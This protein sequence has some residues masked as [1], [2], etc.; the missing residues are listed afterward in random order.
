MVHNQIRKILLLPLDVILTCSF[1]VK[2]LIF[3]MQLSSKFLSAFPFATSDI[4]SN[5]FRLGLLN[6]NIILTFKVHVQGGLLCVKHFIKQGSLFY[7][8]ANRYP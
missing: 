3:A 1:V 5:V 2:S 8:S 7:I 4:M 6:L